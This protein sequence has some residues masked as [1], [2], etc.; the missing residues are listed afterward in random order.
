MSRQLGAIDAFSQLFGSQPCAL[1]IIPN[2]PSVLRQD[3]GRL[4]EF[5]GCC[6]DDYTSSNW[7]ACASSSSAYL[8]NFSAAS[9]SCSLPSSGQRPVM[10]K[11]GGNPPILITTCR[12]QSCLLDGGI[13]REPDMMF[14]ADVARAEVIDWCHKA[15]AR[16]FDGEVRAIAPR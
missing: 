13:T 14:D 8:R 10:Y 7:A 12:W 3:A 16:M 1:G 6:H 5:L 15:A 9:R 4:A 11:G 2:V